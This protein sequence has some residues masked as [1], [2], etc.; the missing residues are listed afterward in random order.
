MLDLVGHSLLIR[1]PSGVHAVRAWLQ[2]GFDPADVSFSHLKQ[3]RDLPSPGFGGTGDHIPAVGRLEI[4]R[5]AGFMIEEAGAEHDAALTIYGYKA[6]VPDPRYEVAEAGFK[7]L[8]AAP[9]AGIAQFLLGI[10]TLLARLKRTVGS[11]AAVFVALAV[12]GKRII[13]FAVIL[14]HA[15]EII[16]GGFDQLFA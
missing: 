7:L 9:R 13:T 16:V 11:P 14:L 12:V 1:A 4:A 3:L 5:F 6:P 8:L 10:G 2:D 15:G